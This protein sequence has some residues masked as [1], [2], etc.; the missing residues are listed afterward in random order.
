GVTITGQNNTT[1]T[2][3]TST[4]GNISINGSGVSKFNPNAIALANMTINA[5]QGS[6]SMDGALSLG[7]ES[8]DSGPSSSVISL[9]KGAKEGTVLN[10]S[11]KNNISINATGPGV[12]V[13]M[14]GANF[15][16]SGSIT[17]NAHG[18]SSG[19]SYAVAGFRNSSFKAANNISV[20][21]VGEEAENSVI[22]AAVAFLGN[23]TFDA[24]HTYIK[25]SHNNATTDMIYGTAGVMFTSSNAVYS[26][27]RSGNVTVNG[28]ISVDGSSKGGGAGVILGA[29]MNVSGT[30]DIKGHSEKGEGIIFSTTV[31]DGNRDRAVELNISIGRGGNISGTSDSGPGVR[32]AND[33]NKV[34]IVTGSGS[35]LLLSGHSASGDGVNLKG[36]VESKKNDGDV[37]GNV[38]L[39]GSSDS[40][41]GVTLSEGVVSGIAIHGMSKAG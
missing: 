14:D 11:A 29:N 24:S 31:D 2:S 5:M 4:A 18:Q 32:N 10:F 20:I 21:A 12:A 38:I 23:T 33:K 16:S 39:S 26:S 25:G 9:M 17:V 8:G 28:S 30:A 37:N 36:L 41:N 40:G 19:Y 34:N 27:E 1:L 15:N 35:D 6:I 7:G 22:Q 13:Y 3:I